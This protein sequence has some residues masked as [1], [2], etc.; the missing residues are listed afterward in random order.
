MR[1][2]RRLAEWCARLCGHGGAAKLLG[3]ATIPAEVR[4]ID[5]DG[6]R[7]LALVE[8]IQRS[9]LSPIEEAN[10]YKAM[11][12]SG[13]TQTALGERIGKGQSYI[14]TKLRLLKLPKQVQQYL[15]D[16]LL[17]EGHAKQ[18]LRLDSYW[19]IKDIAQHCGGNPPNVKPVTECKRLVDRALKQI[20][21]CRAL[22]S[23]ADNADA[24]LSELWP[25]HTFENAQHLRNFD[26]VLRL[27]AQALLPINYRNDTGIDAFAWRMVGHDMVGRGEDPNESQWRECARAVLRI[28]LDTEDDESSAYLLF[29][30]DY[31]FTGFPVMSRDILQGMPAC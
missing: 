17:T 28:M 6:A 3:W 7:W 29:S 31:V 14:A 19:L 12:D 26:K 30:G 8:N 11:L 5:A 13:I 22:S 23:G 4:N 20:E 9:D 21:L 24:L 1:R 10:A 25:T 2:A 16:G 18:L 27:A 15:A